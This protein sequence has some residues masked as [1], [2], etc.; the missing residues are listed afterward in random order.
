MDSSLT[1]WLKAPLSVWRTVMLTLVVGAV[2]A[3]LSRSTLAVMCATVACAFVLSAYEHRYWL[4]VPRH[5]QVRDVA[6]RLG[7]ALSATYVLSATQFLSI[8]KD[9]FA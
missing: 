7:L 1:R 4:Q 6:L 3:A 5:R 9:S 2:V 8:L